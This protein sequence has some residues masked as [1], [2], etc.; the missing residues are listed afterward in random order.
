MKLYK[1]YRYNILLYYFLKKKTIVLGG[2]YNNVSNLNFLDLKLNLL[3]NH[4]KI[5]R[6]IFFDKV[7]LTKILSN[8]FSC[9]FFFVY[10][11]DYFDLINFNKKLNKLSDKNLSFLPFVV[12]DFKNLYSYDY[13]YLINL[14]K[15]TN[16]L[17]II[18]KY[19]TII[20]NLLVNLIKLIKYK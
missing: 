1:F 9:N 13:L 4:I 3:R 14:I 16:K 2:F 19:L 5:L 11:D 20:V 17:T 8:Y 18:V 12:F 10:F 7:K 6:C 15:F